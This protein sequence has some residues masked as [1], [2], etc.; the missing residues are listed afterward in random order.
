MLLRK[1]CFHCIALLAWRLERV[2]CCI[3]RRRLGRCGLGYN[4]P[5][6]AFVL[7]L[8]SFLL[9]V[10][11]VVNMSEYRTTKKVVRL[12]ILLFSFI[13]SFIACGVGLLCIAA[14]Q[15]YPGAHFMVF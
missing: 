13:S 4:F 5:C 15:V 10:T 2:A 9:D 12:D 1:K 7:A 8:F 14:A 11:L 6:L 3:T